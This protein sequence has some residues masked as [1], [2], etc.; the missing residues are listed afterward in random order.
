MLGDITRKRGD[1]YLRICYDLCDCI[2]EECPS[3]ICMEDLAIDWDK[4]SQ[5]ILLPFLMKIHAINTRAKKYKMAPS[6]YKEWLGNV[7]NSAITDYLEPRMLSLIS[8]ND[9]LAGDAN[10]IIGLIRG[11][12]N[13]NKRG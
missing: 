11:N 7:I 12:R 3:I 8:S 13:G 9:Q 1:E 10:R 5:P 6:L 4:S 2:C